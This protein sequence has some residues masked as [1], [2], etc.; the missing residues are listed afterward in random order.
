MLW[1]CRWVCVSLCTCSSTAPRVMQFPHV[2]LRPLLNP[3]KPSSG[4]LCGSLSPTLELNYKGRY[5]FFQVHHPVP[6]MPL[7]S[8]YLQQAPQTSPTAGNIPRRK[9]DERN[10]LASSVHRSVRWTKGDNI[11]VAGFTSSRPRHVPPTSS[12]LIMYAVH[13]VCQNLFLPESQALSFQTATNT[14][15][16]HTTRGSWSVNTA[17][18]RQTTIV[19]FI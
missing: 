15:K 13:N 4:R 14:A 1:R 3:S 16:M 9:N 5:I 2:L 10:S 6:T 18:P 17:V 19:T 12:N 8:A 7:S 11:V